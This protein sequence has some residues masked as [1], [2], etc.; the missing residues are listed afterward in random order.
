MSRKDLFRTNI[1]RRAFLADNAMGIGMFALA[2]LLSEEKLLGVPK[3]D[4]SGGT[5]V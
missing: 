2:T 4:M 3:S 1:N 5:G